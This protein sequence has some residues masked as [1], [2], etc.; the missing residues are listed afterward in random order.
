MTT[1]TRLHNT[2]YLEIILGGMYAGKTS[3]LIEIY[4][5][6]SY[7]GK[8]IIVIN[9]AEDKRYDETMLSTHDGIKIPCAMALN[10][11]DEW[12]NPT[13]EYYNELHGADIILINEGQFFKNL[14]ETVLKMVEDENKVVYICGLDGD[15]KREKFGELLDLIPYC[16]RVEKLTSLCSICRNGTRGIFSKRVTGE[17]N[18]IVIGSDN[19]LP[20]C[21]DC[22]NK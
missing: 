10:L 19:Y 1:H 7:I 14:L 17:T 20:V 13:S 16:D 2:G 5:T 22:Y 9:Y 21:R 15:F 11:Y 3:R 4:K 8:K 12:T 18:Q 6:Y